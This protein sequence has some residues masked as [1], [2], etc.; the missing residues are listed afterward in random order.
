MEC[1]LTWGLLHEGLWGLCYLQRRGQLTLGLLS[2]L[3][4]SLQSHVVFCQIHSRL[5]LELLDNVSEE[6]LVEVLSS[7]EGISVGR[8]HLK[9]PL[10]DLQDGDIK[11]T[12]TQVIDGNTG[13]GKVISITHQ[14]LKKWPDSVSWCITI[15]RPSVP[16][17]SCVFIMIPVSISMTK[18][19]SFWGP[20][21][22]TI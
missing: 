6:V 1:I 18:G 15:T 21:T 19:H 5:S 11:R 10:L 8:L 16:G 20:H 17:P 22:H 4:D 2:S 14:K 3:P 13:N 9:N 12:S 7:K